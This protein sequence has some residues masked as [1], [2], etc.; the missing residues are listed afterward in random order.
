MQAQLLSWAPQAMSAC[1]GPTGLRQRRP[2]PT[3][4]RMY[5]ESGASPTVPAS[6]KT[7]CSQSCVL[8]LMTMG[9]CHSMLPTA[10]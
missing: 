6:R 3:P 2:V 8:P 5:M 4:T 9:R 1:T 7:A 10:M